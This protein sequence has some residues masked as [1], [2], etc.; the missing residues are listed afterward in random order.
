ML[1]F[2]FSDDAPA[3][4]RA[5]RKMWMHI[6][7]VLTVLPEIRVQGAGDG[8][9]RRLSPVDHK[10]LP[11]RRSPDTPPGFWAFGFPHESFQPP[12]V[13]AFCCA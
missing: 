4:Y 1:A 11:L 3:A 13:V 12:R 2:V 5:L 7:P 8:S 9:D 10:G 6:F